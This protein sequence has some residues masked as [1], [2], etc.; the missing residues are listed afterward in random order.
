[1]HVSELQLKYRAGCEY[2]CHIWRY[3][4]TV[5][6]RRYDRTRTDFQTP[7]EGCAP[8]TRGTAALPGHANEQLHPQSAMLI[9]LVVG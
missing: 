2:F 5:V 8:C 6:Q 3:I 4:N 9:H 1:M 7:S